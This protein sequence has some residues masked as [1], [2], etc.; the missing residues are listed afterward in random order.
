MVVDRP[1]WDL[2]VFA[3]EMQTVEAWS[4]GEDQQHRHHQGERWE[5]GKLCRGERLFALAT[6]GGHEP[7]LSIG[8]IQGAGIEP[9][10]GEL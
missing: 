10:W 6:I 5:L 3:G 2:A 7:N 1:L 8:K 9:A 4:W